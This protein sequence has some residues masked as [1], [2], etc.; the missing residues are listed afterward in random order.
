MLNSQPGRSQTAIRRHARSLFRKGAK[1]VHGFS[2]D[3]IREGVNLLMSAY[4]MGLR[5]A[6][7]ELA[8]AQADARSMSKIERGEEI[9]L[10]LYGAKRGNPISALELYYRYGDVVESSRMAAALRS[11]SSGSAEASDILSRMKPPRLP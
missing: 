9:E 8:L 2:K 5:E 10:L 1:L 11:V 6:G 7:L 4:R 3:D